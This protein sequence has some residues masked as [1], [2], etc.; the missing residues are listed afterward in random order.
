MAE[1]YYAV[2]SA[3]SK[4]ELSLHDRLGGHAAVSAVIDDFVVRMAGH[5]QVGHFFARVD[6]AP[7]SKFRG[8]LVE[9]ISAAT[10]GNGRYRGRDMASAHAAFKISESDWDV[11]VA[12]L[13]DSLAKFSVPA[14][15]AKELLAIIA[16]LK[17]QIVKRS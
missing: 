16:P 15:E 10:G 11:T 14:R 17:Q 2:M 9:F 6:T 8:H 3:G 12:N 1:C 7:G 13:R 5:P 4:P